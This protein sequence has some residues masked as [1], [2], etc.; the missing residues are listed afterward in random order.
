MA[1]SVK[2]RC[3]KIIGTGTADFMAIAGYKSGEGEAEEGRYAYGINFDYPDFDKINISDRNKLFT[4]AIDR[5]RSVSQASFKAK[6]LAGEMTEAEVLTWYETVNGE[7][8]LVFLNTVKEKAT[9]EVSGITP[10]ISAARDI[11]RDGIIPKRFPGDTISTISKENLK[12][13]MAEVKESQK[14]N[15]ANWQKALDKAPAELEKRAKAAEK[16]A[17]DFA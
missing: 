17:A 9:R 13:I 6:I 5:V 12:T 2:E 3:D 7:N 14:A 15:N 1:K 8:F 16:A 10:L 4:I 11:L